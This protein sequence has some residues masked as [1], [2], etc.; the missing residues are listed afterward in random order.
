MMLLTVQIITIKIKLLPASWTCIQ[1]FNKRNY[2]FRFF[3][4]SHRL[5]VT[6]L[7]TPL[8]LGTVQLIENKKR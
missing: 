5:Q 6:S 1:F 2:L 8:Q 3:L 7:N 4:W